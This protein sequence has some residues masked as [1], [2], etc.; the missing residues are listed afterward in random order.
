MGAALRG[1]NNKLLRSVHTITTGLN[2]TEI[3]YLALC[4]SED[5]QT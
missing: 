1:A 3:I 4:S 5:N 2:S